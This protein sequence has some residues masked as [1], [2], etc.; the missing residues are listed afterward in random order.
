[1]PIRNFHSALAAVFI[2]AIAALGAIPAVAQ[3]RAT[4]K[5]HTL[6]LASIDY[7]PNGRYVATGSYDKT[8]KIWDAATGAEI[9]TL[10]G[11]DATVE[12]VRF[13]PDGKIL[14]SGSHDNTIK[15]WDVVS[16][17]ARA[18]LPHNGAVR[19]LAFSHDSKILGSGS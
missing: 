4:L 16:G 8:A 10:R 7:S 6:A 11:H 9:I 14:A 18:T 17:E 12:A 15:L 3:I 5:G 2:L 13:S 1:M 19:S